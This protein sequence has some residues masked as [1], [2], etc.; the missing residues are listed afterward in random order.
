MFHAG[1]VCLCKEQCL[2][3]RHTCTVA[4]MAPVTS[5]LQGHYLS[6]TEVEA[7]Q[8]GASS[9]DAHK[10]HCFR[11]GQGTHLSPQPGK[12]LTPKMLAAC[13]VR[14]IMGPVSA[15][16]NC[17]RQTCSTSWMLRHDS[18]MSIEVYTHGPCEKSN[19][20]KETFRSSDAE[21][22]KFPS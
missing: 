16:G 19:L 7:G 8:R 13:S 6:H 22:R 14:S 21:A 2:Q 18:K 4:S 15:S 3:A 20:Q 12:N 17:Q 10:V 1:R 11:R 9:K 5:F